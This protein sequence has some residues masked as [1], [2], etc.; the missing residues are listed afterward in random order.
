M[1][2]A[3]CA[4]RLHGAIGYTWEYDLQLLYKRAKS[5]LEL[6][7]SPRSYRERIASEVLAQS[8]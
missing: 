6:F 2:T 7:G 5:N 3:D 8:S 4:L 1:R